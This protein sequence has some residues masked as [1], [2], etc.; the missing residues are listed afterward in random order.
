MSDR[1]IESGGESREDDRG[2]CPGRG[3]GAS[4]GE[5]AQ[6]DYAVGY[7]KPPQHTRFRKGQSGNA[8][9][10][11]R[12]SLNA[13]TSLQR[14]LFEPIAIVENGRKVKRNRMELSHLQLANKAAKGDLRAI[15]V[16]HRLAS[17]QKLIGSPETQS[18]HGDGSVGSPED[19]ETY[20]AFLKR[21][22]GGTGK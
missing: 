6:E 16:L 11:V 19:V 18:E 5:M 20:E 13:R 10:R 14:V 9:G 3:E 2:K 4:G 17:Q 21:V 7:G 12:G 8:R 22:R 15:E 1:Q